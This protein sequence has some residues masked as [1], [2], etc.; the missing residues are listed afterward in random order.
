MSSE[1]VTISTSKRLT[2]DSVTNWQLPVLLVLFA[3]SVVV[4]VKTV[5]DRHE[6]RA[7]YVDLH[8]LEKERDRLAAQWSR[9][10]LEQGTALNQVR[11]EQYARWDLGMSLPK[12]SEIKMVKESTDRLVIKDTQGLFNLSSEELEATS[13]VVLGD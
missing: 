7:A 3:M 8:K 2:I 4:G 12:T 6:A 1:K 5:V 13:K 11:V 10:K 9:L